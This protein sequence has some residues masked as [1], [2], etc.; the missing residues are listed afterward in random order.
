MEAPSLLL[1]AGAGGGRHNSLP[2]SICHN[3]SPHQA[4]RTI[5]S[6]LP[7]ASRLTPILSEFLHSLGDKESYKAKPLKFNRYSQLAISCKVFT[8]PVIN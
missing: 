6:S 3:H 4:R 8:T 5:T 1:A 2:S 7:L